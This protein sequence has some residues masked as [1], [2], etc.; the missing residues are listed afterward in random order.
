MRKF[1]V[2]SPLLTLFL[3]FALFFSAASYR[4]VADGLILHEPDACPSTGCAAGQRLNFL[5]EFSAAPAYFSGDNTQ[6][7][8][9]APSDGES[10]SGTA[11]WADYGQGWI[12]TEGILSGETYTEGETQSLCTNNTEAGYDWLAGAY[13]ELPGSASD[14]IEFVLT[15]QPT[16]DINGDVIVKVFEAESG[17]SAWQETHYFSQTIAVAAIEATVYAG[18]T[19]GACGSYSPCFINSGDDLT[20]GLGTGLRDA[21]NALNAGDEIVILGEYT[22]KSNPV[23]IDKS[24]TISGQDS[25]LLTYIGAACGSPMLKI[26]AGATIQDLAINDGNCVSPSRDLIDID[27]PAD[28]TIYHNTLNYGQNAIFVRDNTGNVLISSNHIINNLNYAVLRETGSD[29]GTITLVANNIINNRN[30]FQ[31]NCNQRGSADHNFWGESQLAAANA[32][33]C[34]VD[35]GKR[36]GAAIL[37]SSGGA[38]VEVERK[39]VTNTLSYA[40]DDQIGVQRTAG[41]DF[42]V[43]IV[44]HG[45]GG[46][47]H[48]PFLSTGSGLLNACSNFYDIF[49][50]EGAAASNLVLSLKYD[51]NSSC[52]TTIESADYCGQANSA[53]YPLWWYDPANDVTDGWDRTGQ[54][55]DGVGSSGAAG[56]TTTCHTETDEIRVTIDNSGRPG[57]STDLNYTPFV[58]GFPIEQGVTLNQFSAVF[59]VTENDLRWTTSSEHNIDG[60]HIL[61][62]DSENGVYT[63]IT[64]RIENIGDTYIGGIYNYTDTD[65]EFTKVYYYKLEV[66]DENG[67]TVEIYGPISVLTSTATPTNTLTSTPTITRTPAPTRTSTPYYYRSPTSYYR[68]ATSTP[69]PGPTQVRTYG[70]TSTTGSTTRTT[71]PASTSGSRTPPGGVATDSYPATGYPAGPTP[72][73]QTGTPQPTSK[74]GDGGSRSATGTPGATPGGQGENTEAVDD[75]NEN[76][77]GKE[78]SKTPNRPENI[79]WVYLIMGTLSGLGMVGAIGYFV[80]KNRL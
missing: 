33:N 73:G 69:R 39:T 36:L 75:N 32:Q 76:D 60:F 71:T 13:T 65:I 22:I 72:T 55:P 49:L 54:N 20:D 67:E 46:D 17:G 31:V 59:D 34:G 68:P 12:S 11:S 28:V 38:G 74:S 1:F 23:T 27:S 56:Q 41:N 61:R 3:A 80:L 79:Q 4:N 44:N 30:G 35:N 53:A 29:A 15:I 16:T 19:S 6:V 78:A 14:Q 45:Q 18:E 40:F 48:I 64:P 25:S 42:D 9:Y 70:P 51:L 5:V 52:I 7:C 63:R 8:V 62:S 50:A 10:G 66:V 26:F 57:L 24:V 37:Q 21:V 43:Y 77:Q 47:S 2:L 58:I